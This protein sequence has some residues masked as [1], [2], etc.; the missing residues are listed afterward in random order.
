MKHKFLAK[1]ARGPLSGFAWPTPAGG[2][3]GAWIEIEG[4]LGECR[5]GV[6]VCDAPDLAHWIH[7]ELWELETD[8]DWIAG[9]DCV[10]VRRARLVRRIDAWSAAAQ[11]FADACIEH[12]SSQAAAR[13]D[14][15][16]LLD[17]ARMMAANGYAAM[18]AYTSAVAVGRS[19]ADREIDAHYRRERAW[20]SKWIADHCLARA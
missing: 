4:P 2:A 9:T 19:S 16:E 5:R 7:D 8:G 11:R 1:G 10:V 13:P 18:C 14:V 17:D 6:H 15:V 20:Q 3:P 12:A